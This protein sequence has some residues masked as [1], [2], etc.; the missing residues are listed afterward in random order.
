M[1]IGIRVIYDMC[2]AI[3][4]PFTDRVFAGIAEYI[5]RHTINECKVNTRK[6]SPWKYSSSLI[7]LN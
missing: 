4:R 2:V 1:D 3:P 5:D 6:K 7:L